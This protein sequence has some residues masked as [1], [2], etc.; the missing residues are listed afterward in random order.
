MPK[1]TAHCLV[2]NEQNWIWY[3]INS[4]LNWIDEILVWDTGSSDKTVEIIKTISSPKIKFSQLG[5]LSAKQLIHARQEM[6]NQSHDDW[7]MIL[8]GD[9]VWT[10]S[11]IA[12]S[13][14]IIREKDKQHKFLVNRYRNLLGDVYHYQEEA[15]GQYRIG[16]Y[17]G[18]LT[19]R[20][21]NLLAIPGLHYRGE[22]P[23]EGL[24]YGS[25]LLLQGMYTDEPMVNTPYLHATHLRQQNFKY[26]LGY[27]MSNDFEYPKCFYLPR[28]KIVPSPW[29]TRSWKYVLNSTWQTPLKYIKRRL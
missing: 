19:I 27:S 8:D 26:E 17:S 12:E 6:L 29:T 28:P 13:I 4:I 11:A 24:G 15:A 5:Q 20:F 3:S 9:E 21:V 7:M 2:K 25:G 10:E 14:K 16:P 18:H 23:L 22:Y 1:I